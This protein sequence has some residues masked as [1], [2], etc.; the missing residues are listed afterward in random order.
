[1]GL[2]HSF[3]IASAVIRLHV[4][5]SISISSVFFLKNTGKHRFYVNL[6]KHI[7]SSESNI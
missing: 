4:T 2:S 1:M 3:S 7:E 6:C 5:D